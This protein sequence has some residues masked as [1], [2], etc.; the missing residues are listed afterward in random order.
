[1]SA[2]WSLTGGKPDIMAQPANRAFPIRRQI[3]RF[4]GD[5][6]P[7]NSRVLVSVSVRAFE[8]R[9]LAPVSASKNSVPGGQTF[10]GSPTALA[11]I[12]NFWGHR[13]SGSRTR[14]NYSGLSP[15]SSNC[16][17][18]SVGGSR[19]A[20]DG[21]LFLFGTVKLRPPTAW[22]VDFLPKGSRPHRSK[23]KN[24]GFRVE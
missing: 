1:M 22:L 13:N 19:R 18:H 4:C 12:S 3:G 5:F 10:S 7:L 17:L 23:G 9:F 21:S 24:W 14:C 2:V 20:A 16:R 6:R 8:W 15:S 11:P